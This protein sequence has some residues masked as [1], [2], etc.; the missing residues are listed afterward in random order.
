MPTCPHDQVCLP[1]RQEEAPLLQP[2]PPWALPPQRCPRDRWSLLRI[3]CRHGCTA[4]RTPTSMATGTPPGRSS[5]AKRCWGPT[6]AGGGAGPDG[7]GVTAQLVRSTGPHGSPTPQ[8][9]YPKDDHSHP[10]QLDLL[11][12]Q[13]RACPAS[14]PLV[15]A[16]QQACGSAVCQASCAGLG[17]SPAVRTGSWSAAPP[18]VD[19]LGEP[20]SHISRFTAGLS[21]WAPGSTPRSP[22]WIRRLGPGEGGDEKGEGPQKWGLIYKV[23]SLRGKRPIPS[24]PDTVQ[25]ELQVW[26]ALQPPASRPSHR[27]CTTLSLRP[28]CASLRRSGSR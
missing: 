8:V 17:S 27:S 2:R 1:M 19:G 15:A 21:S 16:G 11:F 3:P 18:A 6:R 7:P 23:P 9:F 22:V 13:V 25:P 28:A 4:S 14:R 12:R 10:V 5:C 20:T 26:G 24:R